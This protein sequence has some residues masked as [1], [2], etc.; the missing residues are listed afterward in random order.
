MMWSRFWSIGKPTNSCT[1]EKIQTLSHP[2]RP[3]ASSCQFFLAGKKPLQAPF[4]KWVDPAKSPHVVEA[5]VRRQDR[6][7][8]GDEA[9]RG[10]HAVIG[11]K[12]R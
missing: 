8:A 2:A 10:M 4:I 11:S 12:L 9:R 3:L 6:R 5:D 1:N 7:D